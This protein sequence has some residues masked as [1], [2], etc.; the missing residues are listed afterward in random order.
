M[1]A[2][3]KVLELCR[4]RRAVAAAAA[5]APWPVVGRWGALLQ[6]FPTKLPA[7]GSTVWVAA[8]ADRAHAAGADRRLGPTGGWGRQADADAPYSSLPSGGTAGWKPGRPQALPAGCRQLLSQVRSR[9]PSGR[10]PAARRW[11]PP[12]DLCV[13]CSRHLT[14]D[15]EHISAGK[16]A[17]GRC[18]PVSPWRQVG[19]LLCGGPA[20][21]RPA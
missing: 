14:A 6:R 1:T 12:S 10:G 4:Y 18:A 17:G 20:G 15:S 8:G 3:Q 11:L 5:A 9:L 21:R 2:Y 7:V 13:L 16:E 19:L